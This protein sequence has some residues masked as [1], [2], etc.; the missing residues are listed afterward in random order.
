MKRRDFLKSG[1]LISLSQPLDHVVTK[2]NPAHQIRVN[3]LNSSDTTTQLYLSNFKEKLKFMQITDL[4]FSDSNLDDPGF[5]DYS[6]RM[7]NAYKSVRHYKNNQETNTLDLFKG[8][9]NHA[10]KNEVELLMLTGDIFNYPS[11]PAVAK[12]IEVLKETNIP[13]YYTSGNHDW[14]YEGMLGPMEKLRKDWI[15]Q[16]LSPMY[17]S[18]NPY[19]YSVE[20]KGINMIVIDNS[21][22]QIS[23]EQYNFFRQQRLTGKPM[24]L[25]VHIPIYMPGLPV[26]TCGHP[27]WGE[28]ADGGHEIE[29]RER[30]SAT[31]NSTWTKRFVEE[32]QHAENLLCV[33]T[34]HHHENRVTKHQDVYQ[35]ISLPAFRG[36]YRMIELSS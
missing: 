5:S 18:L 31:G 4:H 32:L 21:T 28:S 20:K 26:S 17:G 35:I 15:N 24:I 8:I 13:F 29:R 3:S 34:G 11:K 22:Y 12:L 14:H 2:I 36:Y 7:N 6:D 1:A 19:Y 9:L 23:E 33:F 30:W 27:N 10:V 16:A 25:F